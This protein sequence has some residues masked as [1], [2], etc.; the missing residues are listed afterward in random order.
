[1]FDLCNKQIKVRCKRTCMITHGVHAMACQGLTYYVSHHFYYDQ[2]DNGN[3]IPG[4]LAVQ[5]HKESSMEAHKAKANVNGICIGVPKSRAAGAQA[6]VQ[7][8]YMF[9]QS[10]DLVKQGMEPEEPSVMTEH[11]HDDKAPNSEYIE[12]QYSTL[13]KFGPVLAY[14]IVQRNIGKPHSEY[15]AWRVLCK[16]GSAR[17]ESLDDSVVLQPDADHH[18]NCLC[19]IVCQTDTQTASNSHYQSL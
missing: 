3:W 5:I 13:F 6:V 9:V 4:G 16:S 7:A 15:I 17:K 8:V 14:G 18:D 11:S 19:R 1:M 10:P 2:G 12:V